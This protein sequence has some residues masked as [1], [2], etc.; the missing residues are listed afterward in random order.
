[1][2]LRGFSGGWGPELLSRG[3]LKRLAGRPPLGDLS[4]RT[5]TL[6]NLA[7]D[8]LD[9]AMVTGKVSGTL[10]IQLSEEEQ[11]ELDKLFQQ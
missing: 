3:N 2:K 11:E 4:E 9:G 5:N 8:H 1:M 10:E 6:T 7:A